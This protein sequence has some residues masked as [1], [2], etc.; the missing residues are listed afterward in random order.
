MAT[1]NE[2]KQRTREAILD[3]ATEYFATSYYDEV[4]LADIAKKAGVSQQTVVNHFGAKADLYLT[5]V[6]ERWV[7][8]IEKLRA[9]VKTGD[10]G[11]I[12]RA[13]CDD[14]EVTGLATMRGQ[15]LAYRFDELAQVMRGGRNSHRS[16]VEASFGDLLPARGAAR[17]RM[18]T[19]LATAL[20]VRTW[21]QLRHEAGLSQRATRT[22]LEQLVGAIVASPS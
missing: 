17:D 15:A 3:A 19:L 20:D 2:A 12:V 21:T 8:I 18:V 10:I 14:Y 5:G 13:I 16:W 22:H 1:R 9:T 11:S 6:A 4:T 7:P